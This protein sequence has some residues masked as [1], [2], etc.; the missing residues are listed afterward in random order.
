MKDTLQENID[1]QPAT[2]QKRDTYTWF[3][4][5]LLG[6]YCFLSI[7]VLSFMP[8]MPVDIIFFFFLLIIGI[9]IMGFILLGIFVD[10]L[11]KCWRCA[12]SKSAPIIVLVIM[13]WLVT[14]YVPFGTALHW[15]RLQVSKPVYLI[16]IAIMQVPDGALRLKSWDWGETIVFLGGGFEYI[17]G[18]DDSDQISWPAESRSAN[19]GQQAKVVKLS[20]NFRR[21]VGSLEHIEGHFYLIIEKY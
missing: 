13:L 11:E 9:G 14:L 12:A 10:A 4:T 17:L 18:Y 5:V 19:W 3:H 20:H 6:S 7:L 21:A 1:H 15:V 16:E 8:S 2:K